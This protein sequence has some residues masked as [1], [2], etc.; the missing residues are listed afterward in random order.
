MT[1]LHAPFQPLLL[2]RLRPGGA[3]IGPSGSTATTS[4]RFSRALRESVRR[5]VTA[6]LQARARPLHAKIDRFPNVASSVINYGLPDL[7]GLVSQQSSIPILADLIKTALLRF[8]PRLIPETV[9]VEIAAKGRLAGV[10]V[11]YDAD[12]D[13]DAKWILQAYECRVSGVLR[14]LRTPLQFWLRANLDPAEAE[15]DFEMF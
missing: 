5:E 13:R 10:T 8:E 1:Q 12:E 3:E 4:E 7:A 2:D 14:P 6:I 15:W 9:A 11:A